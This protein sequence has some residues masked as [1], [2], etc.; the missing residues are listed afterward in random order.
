MHLQLHVFNC[1]LDSLDHFSDI[2]IIILGLK[3][4]GA[5]MAKKILI[6]EMEIIYYIL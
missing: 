1:N 2:M 6:N 5:K 3:Q 4:F